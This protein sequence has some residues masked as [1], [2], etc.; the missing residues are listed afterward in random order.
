MTATTA[1][2]VDADSLEPWL[3]LFERLDDTLASV[4]SSEALRIFRTFGPRRRA[5]AQ[6]R[7]LRERQRLMFELHG[8]GLCPIAGGANAAP[9]APPLRPGTLD[10]HYA[11]LAQAF[12]QCVPAAQRL[13]KP[14]LAQWLQD[15]AHIHQEHAL[16]LLN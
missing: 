15:R 11:L 4:G 6:Q 14:A 12:A 8:L 2:L 7:L 13:G 16:F 9:P 5:H 1:P 10:T 3:R